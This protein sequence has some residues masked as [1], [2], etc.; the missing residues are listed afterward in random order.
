MLKE[1]MGTTELT[2]NQSRARPASRRSK[3]PVFVI[4]CGRSGTTLLYHMI[5]SAGNFAV[6]R[7][8]SNVINLLE[9]RF[10]DLSRPTAK[11]KLLEAWYN[12]R[13]YTL[14][15]LDRQE[16]G[17]KVMADVKNGGDFLRAIMGEMARQQGVERWA[18]CTPEH[19]LHLHRI[20]ETIP[21]AL[22]IHIIRD[23]RDNALSTDKQG[24]IH[25]LPWDKKPSVLSA[26]L[27]WEWMVNT[28]RR[29]GKDLGDD[30]T[31]VR[32]EDL[33]AKPQET[34]ARLGQFIEHDLDYDRIQSIGIGSVSEPNTSFASSGKEFSPVGRW[35]TGY[36]AETLSTMEALIG[37][38][39]EQLGYQLASS[40]RELRN[41]SDITRMRSVYRRYFDTKL[42]LKAKTPLG[43]LMVT[44]DLS[45]I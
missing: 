15:G 26:G 40:N 38:T 29:D 43:R 24:Y 17:K 16:I 6:Y 12:S 30:Y 36:P 11:R 23:G 20:K 33:V 22:I 4:G 32:F 35:K 45:W 27:Y 13:L 25:P 19:I 5:L 3:A 42:F 37:D 34:L 9:P 7:T 28:G 31:E 2:R 18:E 39:L 1:T 41:R 44:R 8:E 21:D 10:G 14:S